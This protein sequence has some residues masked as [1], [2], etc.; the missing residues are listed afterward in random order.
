MDYGVIDHHRRQSYA[1]LY[2]L[3]LCNAAEVRK[4]SS[5]SQIPSFFLFC[6][7]SFLVTQKLAA[8]VVRAHHV[9]GPQDI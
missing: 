8:I 3:R 4:K 2:T 9:H 7:V 6:S 5:T 1:V